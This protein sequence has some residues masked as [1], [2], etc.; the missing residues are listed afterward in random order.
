MTG[1]KL[2]WPRLSE[3]DINELEI[4]SQGGDR[5]LSEI[6]VGRQEALDKF[7]QRLALLKRRVDD[8]LDREPAKDLALVFQGAPGAGKTSLLRRIETM[9]VSRTITM[10]ASTLRTPPEGFLAEVARRLPDSKVVRRLW[11]WR[12]VVTGIQAMSFG[13]SFQPAAEDSAERTRH[14]QDAPVVLL[15]DE[16]QKVAGPEMAPQAAQNFRD[17]LDLLNEATHGL[18]VFPVFAGLAESGDLLRKVGHLTRLNYDAEITLSRFDDATQT[19]LLGQFVET[20]LA[21]A[22]PSEATVETWAGAM[23]RDCQGWPMHCRHFLLSLGQGIKAADWRPEATDF[24]SVRMRTAGLRGTYYDSRMQDALE[25]R[26]GIVSAA[27]EE[28]GRQGPLPRDLI[29]AELADADAEARGGASLRRPKLWTLPD[30]TTAKEFFDFM[31]HSGVVQK[32]SKTKFDCPIPSLASH[33]AAM[34][35]EPSDTLHEAVARGDL[36]AVQDALDRN[37]NPNARSETLHATDF[38]SRTPLILAVESG[39][40]A[41][42]KALAEAEASLPEKLRNF[43]AKDAAGLTAADH[44]EVAEDRRILKMLQRVVATETARIRP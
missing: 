19:E 27:L 6:F 37:A 38:R 9:K 7:A 15:F 14:L 16:F 26:Y 31:V 36:R 12:P 32:C 40:V 22:R 20:R 1:D 34:A 25:D 28:L 33:V 11:E 4:F 41:L 17:N 23:V 30:N 29:E 44:A 13:V 8:P 39:M 21:S 43:K 42:V 2:E 5:G 24:D 18:P 35:A 10:P 3:A